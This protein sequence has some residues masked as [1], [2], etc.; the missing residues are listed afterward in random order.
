MSWADEEPNTLRGLDSDE[1]VSA[2][3][4]RVLRVLRVLPTVK[5]LDQP[6]RPALAPALVFTA[7]SAAPVAVLVL[8]SGSVSAFGSVTKPRLPLPLLLWEAKS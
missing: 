6:P 4:L 8:A 7:E 3:V 2:F 5:V 1:A